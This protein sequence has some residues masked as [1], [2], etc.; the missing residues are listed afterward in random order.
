MRSTPRSN[1]NFHGKLGAIDG[2]RLQRRR[3]V[4]ENNA[5]EVK[6]VCG[7]KGIPEPPRTCKLAP[8]YFGT[9]TFSDDISSPLPSYFGR[10]KSIVD[11]GG[12]LVALVVR[13]PNRSAQG[14][15]APERAKS[16]LRRGARAQFPRQ[17]AGCKKHETQGALARR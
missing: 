1:R 13:Q 15:A 3:R 5:D 12:D 9:H 14:L 11:I 16:Q 10:P 17:I 6:L 2:A 7:L 8:L 4:S